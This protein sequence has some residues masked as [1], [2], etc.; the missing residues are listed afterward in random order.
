MFGDKST[1]IYGVI[2]SPLRVVVV[3]DVLHLILSLC[4]HIGSPFGGVVVGGSI[5]PPS[6]SPQK[7]TFGGSGAWGFYSISVSVLIEFTDIYPSP[8][9]SCSKTNKQRFT[10]L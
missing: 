2:N 7:F 4:L 5:P 8:S 10:I 1:D 6:P 3:E 9:E